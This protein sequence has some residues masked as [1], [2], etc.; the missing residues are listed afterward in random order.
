MANLLNNIPTAPPQR[1]RQGFSV[2]QDRPPRERASFDTPQP[3]EPQRAATS[4]LGTAVFEELRIRPGQEP[5]LNGR[6]WDA[7]TFPPTTVMKLKRSK[8]VVEQEVQ[9]GGA[10]V[11]EGIHSGRYELELSGRLVSTDKFRRPET[12]V[13]ALERICSLRAALEIE[14]E[15]LNSRGIYELYIQSW[16]I[17]PPQGFQNTVNFSLQARA[18]QP[19]VLELREQDEEPAPNQ[20]NAEPLNETPKA[21]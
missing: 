20:S 13:A 17:D 12:Q 8:A 11:V 5:V 21:E 9:N 6:Q 16:S 7:Y 3:A 4:P 10:F 1:S 18:Y 19:Q 15:F 14:N 2:P